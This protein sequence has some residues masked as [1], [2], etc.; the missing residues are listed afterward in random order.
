MKFDLVLS[1]IDCDIHQV[2]AA[3]QLGESLGFDGLWTYDH[4]SGGVMGGTSALDVW[5]VLAAIAMS[6]THIDIGPL[7]V[8]ATTRHPAHINTAVATLQQLS[9]GRLI[10]GLGAGAGPESSFADELRM[11]G[12]EL[13]SASFR[14]QRVAETVQLLRALWNGETD[15]H[16]ELLRFVEVEHVALPL[17]APKIVVGANGPRMAELAGTYA[18]GVNLHSWEKDLPEMVNVARA[19]ATRAG[20]HD[21]NVSVET[22][23]GPQWLD[24]SSAE[25]RM[26]DELG[27]DRLQFRWNASLGLDAIRA[28]GSALKT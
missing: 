25:R 6:T 1:N 27:V 26:L 15:F 13:Y 28:I 17:P 2:V 20:R 11:F 19:A 10:L 24:P 7:V 3:A 14:R 5:T 16:G 8:N 18:D 12:M 21:F 23:V 9:N 22:P 4:V